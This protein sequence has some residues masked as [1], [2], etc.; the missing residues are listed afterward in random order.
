M[1]SHEWHVADAFDLVVNRR[2]SPASED[3]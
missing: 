2:T 1:L 3:A